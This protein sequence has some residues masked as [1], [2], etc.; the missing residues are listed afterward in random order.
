MKSNPSVMAEPLEKVADSSLKV[1]VSN[2][3]EA[4]QFVHNVENAQDKAKANV[5]PKNDKSRHDL[6]DDKLQ[7]AIKE[8]NLEASNHSFEEFF[9]AAEIVALERGLTSPI[10]RVAENDFEPKHSPRNATINPKN[11][12]S[13][14]HSSKQLLKPKPSA[15][16]P[17]HERRETEDVENIDADVNALLSMIDSEKKQEKKLADHHKGPE[18]VTLHSESSNSLSK[19]SPRSKPSSSHR[20]SYAKDALDPYIMH[21]YKSMTLANK[22]SKDDEPNRFRSST[23]LCVSGKSKLAKMLASPKVTVPSVGASTEMLFKHMSVVRPKSA[24]SVKG[25]SKAKTKVSTAEMVERLSQAIPKIDNMAPSKHK[26]RP[27]Q[28]YAR[29]EDAKECTFKPKTKKRDNGEN[30]GEEK[31][32]FIDRMEA[33]QRQKVDSLEA[34]MGKAAYDAIIDKKVC[35]T[36]GSKQSFDEY[37]EKRKKCQI[38]NVEY[39][40]KL[41]WAQVGRGFLDKHRKEQ[42]IAEMKRKKMQEDEILA[43]KKFSEKYAQWTPELEKEFFARMD[44]ALAARDRNLK[45]VEAEI[46]KEKYPFRPQQSTYSTHKENGED[47]E[48]ERSSESTRAFLRRVEQDLEKRKA[49]SDYVNPRLL[50]EE[51]SAE[52]HIHSHG[53]RVGSVCR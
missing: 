29:Y 34:Q 31:D 26:L 12:E 21:K 38:C 2:K 45:Q 41:T 46:K 11:E 15:E 52:N 5:T 27:D 22:D 17:R 19:H 42:E 43:Q 36:C 14:S 44:E 7:A 1:K 18:V 37:K 28:M 33:K 24:P 39:R 10:R 16:V 13:E 20:L 50:I 49:N 30:R 53:F 47:F 23:H 3:S 48:Q 9:N 35:P 4:V 25:V 8:V 51:K 32:N 40:S 6:A